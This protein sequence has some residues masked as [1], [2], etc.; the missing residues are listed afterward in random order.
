MKRQTVLQ[1]KLN[2]LFHPLQNSFYNRLQVGSNTCT[3][4]GKLQ[5][6]GSFK[7][8]LHIFTDT[9]SDY[10]I[11]IVHRDLKPANILLAISKKKRKL[12]NESDS[13]FIKYQKGL[14]VAKI[15]D[16]G[17]GKQL[18][19]QSSLGVSMLGESSFRGSKG[20]TSSV[21][22]GPGSVGW[23]APE[24]MAVRWASD[25]SARSDSS[26][27]GAPAA[28]AE[29]SPI[30][31]TPNNRT[32][33]SIDIFSLGCIFYSTLVPG[34]HPFGE[35]WERE[36]N[37][38]HNRPCLGP[39]KKLSPDA[40]DL[41][42]SMLSMNPRL[43]PTAKQICE[44]PF[45][46]SSQQKLTF[47]CD[48]SDRLETDAI[49]QTSVQSINVL[50]IERGA[51][52]I[53]GTSWVKCL[54][55]A[56]INNVQRFRSY[57]PSSARD[58]LRLIRNK[59]HHFDEL[60]DDFRAS[61]MP[62]QDEMLKYFEI[63]FQGLLMHC[64]NCCRELL[65]EED[66]LAIKYSITPLPKSENKRSLPSKPHTVIV[67]SPD[68]ESQVTKSREERKGSLQDIEDVLEPIFADNESVLNGSIKIDSVKM[69]SL[70]VLKDEI[71][72]G[73]ENTTENKTTGAVSDI[74]DII[75]W[76]GST[77]AKTFNC[78]GWGRSEDEWCT[79]IDPV[80][81]K[82][83][84]NLKRAIDDPKFRTRL[85]N[86]WDTSLGT[87]CPMRKKNKCIFAHGAVELRVKEGKRNRWGKLL[88][89]DGNNSN[90][91]HSGGEDT[92]GAAK[93]IEKVRKVE[94]K[95]RTGKKSNSRGKKP[96]TNSKKNSN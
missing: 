40:F 83:D 12:L 54:D 14:F 11:S 23:Q 79:R 47:L 29:S 61:K 84:L 96:A 2:L 53:V 63:R 30:E 10:I 88:D 81:R 37:I 68:K 8:L 17:L 69:E 55:D 27:G 74:D 87:D 3:H 67:Q 51:V 75:V 4:Y 26:N 41:V 86:H 78:R 31:L 64:C 65:T 7:S 94:G 34:F 82:R 16:M 33:R 19:G 5:S 77:A 48:F 90:P 70:P 92:Y 50:A 43:R 91:W 15:S 38:M 45:F 32:S 21:G 56:L 9:F 24:V 1:M 76:E 59:H 93:S 60:P 57:D 52:D 35:W 62:S 25:S 46:W 95:W 36:S 66:P 73:I 20:G 71:D 6:R 72:N 85:C 13:T 42:S 39:L 80:F 89:K 49:S 28:I 58:L 22:V 44:H 18:V